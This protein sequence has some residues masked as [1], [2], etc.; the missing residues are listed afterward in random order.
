MV[1]KDGSEKKRASDGE[2][3]AFNKAFS[4]SLGAGGLCDDATFIV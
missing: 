3:P 4:M 2:K 1:Q